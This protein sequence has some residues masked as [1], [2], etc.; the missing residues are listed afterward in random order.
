MPISQMRTLTLR[1]V[2]CIFWLSLCVLSNNASSSNNSNKYILGSYLPYWVVPLLF[3]LG[4]QK[5]SFSLKDRLTLPG[6]LSLPEVT[7]HYLSKT[8][9]WSHRAQFLVY[10]SY[11]VNIYWMMSN[12][13]NKS[14]KK[15]FY[16]PSDKNLYIVDNFCCIDFCQHFV[17][18]EVYRICSKIAKC[19][20]GKRTGN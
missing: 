18:F 7:C 3:V 6:L 17:K 12:W 10:G 2:S 5:W 11:S 19:F 14:K 8:Q 15:L 13:M 16:Y 1:E 9:S 4:T 20:K